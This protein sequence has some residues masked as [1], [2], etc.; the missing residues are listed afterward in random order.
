MRTPG[1]QPAEA[2]VE[3]APGAASQPAEGAAVLHDGP[4]FGRSLGLF[5]LYTILRFGL[6]GLL[7]LVLWLVGVGWLIA[8][9]IAVVIS[10]PLSWVLLARPRRALAAN[11]EERVN[12][13]I[14]RVTQLNARLDGTDES[15]DPKP[16]GA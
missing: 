7:W 15:D 8:A 14:D 10:I 3:P 13:R 12:A 4:S 6:F 16:P 9:A 11:I 2:P 1:D 5:W